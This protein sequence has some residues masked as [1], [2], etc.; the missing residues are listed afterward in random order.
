MSNKALVQLRAY[1]QQTVSFPAAVTPAANSQNQRGI[2]K[3]EPPTDQRQQAALRIQKAW[4]QAQFQRNFS[5][6]AFETYLSM[7]EDIQDIN[8]SKEM[9]GTTIASHVNKNTTTF[10]PQ[11]PNTHADSVYYRTDSFSSLKDIQTV[12]KQ[13]DPNFDTELYNYVPITFSTT[14]KIKDI[15]K[16]Y[17]PNYDPDKNEK[18]R[19]LRN[20]NDP[21]S[22]FGF[23]RID[24]NDQ[25]YDWLYRIFRV[26]RIEGNFTYKMAEFGFKASPWKV[27][28]ALFQSNPVHTA[29]QVPRLHGMDSWLPD[30]I[31]ELKKRYCPLLARIAADEQCPTHLLASCL[32]GMLSHLPEMN[33]INK[34]TLQ[35]MAILL[36]SAT[37]LHSNDYD[38]FAL[39]FYCFA[40]EI[41]LLIAKGQLKLNFEDFLKDTYDHEIAAFGIDNPTDTSNYQFV[42][43]PANSGTSAMW[44]A[45]TLAQEGLTPDEIAMHKKGDMYY[46]FTTIDNLTKQKIKN[47][48]RDIYLITSGP[49]VLLSTWSGICPG[50]DLNKMIASCIPEKGA[51]LRPITIIID[52]TSGMH[53]NLKIE[54]KWKPF[55]MDGTISLI[56][57]ESHQKFGLGHSDQAQYGKV[58]G[59]CS[60]AEYPPSFLEECAGKAKEDFKNNIDMQIGAYIST[61]AGTSLEKIKEAHFRN[62]KCLRDFFKE[63]GLGNDMFIPDK[64]KLDTE[65]KDRGLFVYGH[66]NS[67]IGKKVRD[68]LE[69]RG[70]FGH[71]NTTWS[72]CGPYFRIAPSA[73]DT[74][75][76]LIEGTE[77]YCVANL[78]SIEQ[79]TELKA[80]V[81]NFISSPTVPSPSDQVMLAGLMQA[82]A[83]RQYKPKTPTD[84]FLWQYAL[85]LMR[86]KCPLLN[87]RK[88]FHELL[89]YRQQGFLATRKSPSFLDDVLYKFSKTTYPI[90]QSD[91]LYQSIRS[92]TLA[93]TH[94]S[95]N[96][97]YLLVLEAKTRLY[98]SRVAITPTLRAAMLANEAISKAIVQVDK[99]NLLSKQT[100]EMLLSDNSACFSK[101][102]LT[103]VDMN[104]LTQVSEQN[105]TKTYLD[106][107]V[108]TKN[109]LLYQTV[110]LLK[111]Y[112]LGQA[113][114]DLLLKSTPT[115][116]KRINDILSS[117]TASPVTPALF[118]KLVTQLPFA[119]A[120]HLEFKTKCNNLAF[121][122]LPPAEANHYL[123]TLPPG[124]LL[125]LYKFL[126]ENK[127]TLNTCAQKSTDCP[128]IDVYLATCE[129]AV[130]QAFRSAYKNECFLSCLGNIGRS[131][132]GK[133]VFSGQDLSISAIED[134]VKINSQNASAKA[135]NRLKHT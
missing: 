77:L 71:Y 101:A 126:S 64:D 91:T 75:D 96:E 99:H 123:N 85:K 6:K 113:E 33:V 78:S 44:M 105:P 86:E 132:F 56:V 9:F 38:R 94:L 108:E 13:F 61:Y 26:F 80:F 28:S 122:L 82:L 16:A 58:F 3:P 25:K 116:K 93:Q 15:L 109:P 100:L 59:I 30:N 49:T 54:D 74:T 73:S 118:A 21:T 5:S 45:L 83:H 119:Q 60:K 22:P 14:L 81:S 134:Y 37:Q 29:T 41:G 88:C 62:G 111:H 35:R 50:T 98:A 36:N 127:D 2:K 133:K 24:K 66:M 89:D 90:A 70:S 69:Y 95:K 10:L 46:E 103:L 114:L 130:V 20:P 42:G 72:D 34:T 131:D 135:L 4:R 63:L 129:T 40:H 17:A 115:E 18:V 31:T 19:L 125:D 97:S 11:N 84:Q 121:L 48:K 27:A 23:I 104:L 124:R 68:H 51:P 12:L 92:V 32:H 102:V 53:R 39:I 76:I 8:L 55:I 117:L 43:I 52:S 7:L 57:H 1:L 65:D 47:P 128:D 107:I 79:I 67:V 106:V 120:L 112:R 110:G 87:G